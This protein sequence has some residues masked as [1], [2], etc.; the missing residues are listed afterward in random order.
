M[1]VR[2]ES[3]SVVEFSV[4]P[5]HNPSWDARRAG[6]VSANV[7]SLC[8]VNPR[9]VHGWILADGTKVGLG[10]L[11]QRVVDRA[12]ALAQLEKLSPADLAAL[13]RSMSPEQL[14]QLAALQSS[15][16]GK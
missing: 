15:M 13:K 11:M 10:P 7:N 9:G 5:P 16:P 12:G 3:V 6:S 4:A 1:N 2:Q 8:K 14:Q